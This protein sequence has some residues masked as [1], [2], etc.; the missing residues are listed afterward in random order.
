MKFYQITW[1]L[2]TILN[3]ILC[4]ICISLS[5]P[6]L[7][8]IYWHWQTLPPRSSYTS[9]IRWSHSLLHLR[10][11]SS[12]SFVDFPSEITI[13]L[14]DFLFLPSSRTT[15]VFG[16][17]FSCVISSSKNNNSNFST[18]KN[19]KFKHSIK[20]IIRKNFKIKDFLERF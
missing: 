16:V 9:N 2:W 8:V 19:I 12:F 5:L 6:K 20:S 11:S 10:I 1:I 15:V 4:P 7:Y 17:V 14:E 13:F 18:Q 3:I